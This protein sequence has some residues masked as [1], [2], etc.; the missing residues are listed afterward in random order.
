MGIVGVD[1]GFEEKRKRE[2]GGRKMRGL[3]AL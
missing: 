2:D 3:A 1:L